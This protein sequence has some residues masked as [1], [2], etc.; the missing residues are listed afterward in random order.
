MT[1]L[2]H[3]DFFPTSMFLGSTTHTFNH[4]QVSP[5]AVSHPP[6]YQDLLRR[7]TDHWSTVHADPGN[8]QIWHDEALFEIFFG[9][10]YARFVER[11]VVHG[12]RVLELGCGEGNLALTLAKRGLSVTALDLS[13]SRL[14]RGRKKAVEVRL[15]HRIDF[16]VADL[17]SATLPTNAFSC[18]VAHDALHHILDLEHLLSQASSALKPGGSLVVMDYIGMGKVRKLLAAGMVGVLP[19]YK[20]YAEKWRLRTRL[21]S[22]LASEDEKRTSLGGDLS[23]LHPES[24]FEEITQRSLL[25]AIGTRFRLISQE[26][27]L[28]FWYYIAPK[29]RTGK[30]LRYP[31]ARM[32]KGLDNLFHAIGVSGAY[33]IIEARKDDH[34]PAAS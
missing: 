12:P 1:F 29:I 15:D 9:K 7:E 33:C 22:F 16:R 24:P 20:S 28:P 30:T 14:E 5:L 34:A 18:V 23:L 11:I 19:T 21:G 4:R 6:Q 27:F 17:N 8:P 31:V 25:T 3:L 26:T 2:L 32:L 10:Q 13:E